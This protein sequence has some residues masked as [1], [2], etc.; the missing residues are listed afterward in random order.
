MEELKREAAES[1]LRNEKHD[2]ADRLKK[3]TS[4][5]K[6]QEEAWTKERSKTLKLTFS[7]FSYTT[8]LFTEIH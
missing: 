4:T 3:V 1:Q 2:L 5:L 6:Q 7:K 8:P